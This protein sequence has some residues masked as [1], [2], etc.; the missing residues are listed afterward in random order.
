MRS[1]EG[2]QTDKQTRAHTSDENIDYVHL[3]E[4]TMIKL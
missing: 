1:R 2:R 3:A 4:I